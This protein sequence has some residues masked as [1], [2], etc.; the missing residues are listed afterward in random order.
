[1]TGYLA[2]V[3]VIFLISAVGAGVHLWSSWPVKLK[4]APEQ[5]PVRTLTI[6]DAPSTGTPSSEGEAAPEQPDEPENT[7]LAEPIDDPTAEQGADPGEAAAAPAGRQIVLDSLE[8]DLATTRALFEN[9]LATFI[10][11]RP[12]GEYEAGH[13]ADAMNI[14]PQMLE[15]SASLFALDVIDPAKVI[16]IYCGGGDCDDSHRVAELLQDLRGLE[17]AHVFVDGFPAWEA[18]EL[19]TASG[20]DPWAE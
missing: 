19:P 2:K 9:N 13:I 12:T 6:P 10:D 16:V 17:Q 20:P 4:A 14:T 18:A 8:I 1:M 7:S 3:I 15:S 11:A 5:P